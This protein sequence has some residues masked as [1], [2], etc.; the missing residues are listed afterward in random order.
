MGFEKGHAKLGGRPPGGLNKIPAGTKESALEVFQGIGG[1]PA[2]IE[3]ALAN[4]ES[5]YTKIW[6]KL[7]PREVDV[8]GLFGMV[9][10]NL[11]KLTDDELAAIDAIYDRAAA[12][13]DGSEG[14]TVPAVAGGICSPVVAERPQSESA[15]GVG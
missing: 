7:L 6:A 15:P 3:W 4:P 14:G 5:F 2:M 13:P 11:S 12:R 1:I 10:H 9:V 8:R